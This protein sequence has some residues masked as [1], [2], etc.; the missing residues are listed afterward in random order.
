MARMPLVYRGRY[1]GMLSLRI[2]V[3]MTT[4]LTAAFII[5]EEAPGGMAL[6]FSSATCWRYG[7]RFDKVYSAAVIRRI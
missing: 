6:Q 3:D 5:I 1:A 4:P 7:V 2:T